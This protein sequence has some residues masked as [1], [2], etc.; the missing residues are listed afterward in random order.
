MKETWEI[1]QLDPLVLQMENKAQRKEL[2]SPL[3]D[4]IWVADSGL[5]S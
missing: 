2:T 3:S 5:K 4:D 1:I